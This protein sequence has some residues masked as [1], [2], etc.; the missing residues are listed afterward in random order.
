MT[1]C[2]LKIHDEPGWPEKGIKIYKFNF[3]V[4]SLSLLIFLYHHLRLIHKMSLSQSVRIGKML[5]LAQKILRRA[6]I[7]LMFLLA[8]TACCWCDS[9]DPNPYDDIPPVVTVEFNYVVPAGINVVRPTAQLQGPQLASAEVGIM[10]GPET[11]ELFSHHV[12]AACLHSPCHI[13]IPL[14]R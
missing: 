9:Y 7:G 2:L 6:T 1:F 4:F 8:G 14:R 12:V 5:L 13:V 10:P 3:L 11:P